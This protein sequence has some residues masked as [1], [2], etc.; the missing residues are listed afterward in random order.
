MS[1]HTTVQASRNIDFVALAKPLLECTE[2]PFATICGEVR[3]LGATLNSFGINCQG[4]ERIGPTGGPAG[5][6]S[7]VP[8]ALIAI[9]AP[10]DAVQRSAS[11]AAVM[12]AALVGDPMMPAL[13]RFIM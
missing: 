13:M 9:M 8:I 5:S 10:L 4:S 6:S 7:G 1:G 2:G 3:Y 11:Y 12:S